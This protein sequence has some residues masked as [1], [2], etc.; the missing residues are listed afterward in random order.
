MRSRTSCIKPS[1]SNLPDG[2]A[3][4]YPFKDIIF[5]SNNLLSQIIDD[6]AVFDICLNIKILI[7]RIEQII[8]SLII[9]FQIADFDSKRCFST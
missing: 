6:A 3:F 4:M 9:H 1:S 5:I 2:F 7:I 8:D